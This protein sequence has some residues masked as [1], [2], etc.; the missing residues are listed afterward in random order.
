MTRHAAVS[1]DDDLAAR[2]ARIT[3]RATDDELARRVH[4]VLRIRRQKLCRNDDLDDLFDHILADRR[5]V[6]FRIVLRGDDDGIDGDGLAVLVAH[7]HLRLAVGT[8]V[9]EFAVLTHLCKA[10][11]QTMCE[12]DRQRHELRR[13]VRRIAEHHALIARTDGVGDIGFTLLRLKRL[14]NAECDV[15]RLLIERY[16][17]AARRCIEAILRTRVADLLHSLADDV[18]DVDVARGRDLADDMHLPRRHQCL[19]RHAPLRIFC[20]NRIENGVRNLIGHLVGMTFRH[21]LGSEQHRFAHGMLH[22]AAAA[23]GK[24]LKKQGATFPARRPQSAAFM[25]SSAKCLQ[26]KPICSIHHPSKKTLFL[27]KESLP[28]LPSH[29]QYL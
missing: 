6:D 26:Q 20:E 25:K 9:A 18:R 7:R 10:T 11:C 21:R 24:Y 8:Q 2:E 19:A 22:S 1:V 3:L 28:S 14:V 4:E 16:E 5:Q 27:R 17:N 15:G 12:C 29:R 13:L 23:C